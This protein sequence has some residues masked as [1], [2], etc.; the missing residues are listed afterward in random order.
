MASLI[1]CPFLPPQDSTY[2]L[3]YLNTLLKRHKQ[4]WTWG[5]RRELPLPIGSSDETFLSALKFH[6]ISRY[7][8]QV[9][10]LYAEPRSPQACIWFIHLSESKRLIT[11]SVLSI[12][13][14]SEHITFLGNSCRSKS[15]LMSLIGNPS[16]DLSVNAL[17]QLTYVFLRMYFN[18]FWLA[19]TWQQSCCWS[20]LWLF[21][22][23]S[24]ILL[25]GFYC[26]RICLELECCCL[27]S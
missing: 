15:Y 14:N 27:P 2:A 4:A 3:I 24:W 20:A 7:T 16:V 21:V 5:S 6:L 18:L 23:R 25:Q 11:L 13:R 26:R 22:K 8:E 9:V 10:F 12:Y 1:N 17:G 19:M